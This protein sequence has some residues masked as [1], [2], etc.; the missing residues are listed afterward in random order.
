MVLHT[1][2]TSP[3]TAAFG[4]CLRLLSGDDAL[5][6]LGDGCYAGLAGSDAGQQL[7]AAG[8][9]LYVLHADA[10]ARGIAELLLPGIE[11][12]DYAG[13]VELTEAHSR[14]LAWY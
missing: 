13:F 14:Q 9:K 12:V 3:A 1:L 6:L 5:L 7:T 4:D 11:L 10:T 8:S 2:N